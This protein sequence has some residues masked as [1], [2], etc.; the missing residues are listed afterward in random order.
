M[1]TTDFLVEYTYMLFIVTNLASLGCELTHLS[2]LGMFLFDWNH[3]TLGSTCNI[4]IIL[5]WILFLQIF[6]G[7]YVKLLLWTHFNILLSES[8]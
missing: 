1:V 2:V 3:A 8:S 5:C 6:L 4:S 7:L